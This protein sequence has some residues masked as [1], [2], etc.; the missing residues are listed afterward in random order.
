M[1]EGQ[2]PYNAGPAKPP[3][4]TLSQILEHL[5]WRALVACS[6]FISGQ[7]TVEKLR[8]EDFRQSVEV[9]PRVC[10]G[11]FLTVLLEAL[12][13]CDARVRSA[14]DSAIRGFAAYGLDVVAV[15][16]RKPDSLFVEARRPP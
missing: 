8:T 3:R 7:S 12:D 9:H 15:A 1:S 16:V 11:Y 4:R 10:D 6:R 13:F 5:R 2:L 14:H